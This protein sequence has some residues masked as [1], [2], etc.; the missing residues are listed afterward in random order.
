[1]SMRLSAEG[2]DKLVDCSD[3]LYAVSEAMKHNYISKKEDRARLISAVKSVSQ[4]L[5]EIIMEAQQRYKAISV[6]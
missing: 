4:L 6:H 5:D 2:E 1:M 3:M